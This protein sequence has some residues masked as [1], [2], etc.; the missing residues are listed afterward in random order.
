VNGLNTVSGSLA[1][2]V[3][4]GLC[5]FAGSCVSTSAGG[6]ARAP[7]SIFDGKSLSGW[8]QKG[9]G[10]AYTVEGGCIVGSTRPQQPN[11][12]LCTV[13][14]YSDFILELD[15]QVDPLLNSG[16]QIRSESRPDYKDGVVHGYQ[17]EIDPSDR[18]WTAGIYDESRRGW[19]VNLEH[20]PLA[21]ASFKQGQWNHLRISAKGDHL[22][23]WLNGVPAADLH[24]TM[25]TTG[26]IGLQVHGVGDRKDELR[27][28]WRNIE[29]T[30]LD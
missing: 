3:G 12:F 25:T 21:R 24:D 13:A 16:V 23:S 15:F 29:L 5:M 22:Q 30:C 7:R 26:F 28:R 8:V 4:V 11:S 6:S 27:I 1:A 14:Q 20:N 18:A 19:L 10:A 9:G 2:I 17:I